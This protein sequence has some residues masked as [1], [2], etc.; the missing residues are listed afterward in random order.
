MN[1]KPNILFIFADDQRAGT[2]GALGNDQIKTPN[3]DILVENGMSFTNGYIQGGS[4]PAVCLPSRAMLHT[5]RSLFS[6]DNEGIEIP[7]CHTLLGEHLRANGYET[8]GTGKWHN[9]SYAYHKSF[10]SGDN[11]FFG[12]MNDHWCVPV[13]RYDPTGKYDK[14]LRKSHARYKAEFMQGGVHSTDF[15]SDSAIDFLKQK[16]EEPFFAYISFLAP[17]DPRTMPDEF[18]NLYN[19]NEINLPENF[20]NY[21][22]IEYDNTQIRDELLAPY[23]RT[24]EDTKN[25]IAEY[26]GMISHLDDRVGKMLS[27]LDESGD[28]ENTIII[29]SGDNGLAIGQHGLFGKQNLYEHS[30]NV[31]LIFSGCGID[32]NVNKDCPVFLF[33]IFPTI[34]DLIGIETPES[35][36]GISFSKVISG[37]EDKTRDVMY[38]CYKDKI[39]AVRK[40]DYKL[41]EHHHN[42]QTTLNL[43]NIKND[44]NEMAN[45]AFDKTHKDLLTQMQ[46]L[47]REQADFYNDNA[48]NEN[49][50]YLNSY[51]K[52]N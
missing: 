31:P 29:Y 9:G 49:N 52:N 14:V 38:H 43:F 4:R 33:D 2:I 44:P 45:L 48:D 12:G 50:P 27:A 37:E 32:K 1:K 46:A 5:G 35:C 26:Y 34:C 40:G 30:I 17:H 41:I 16:H 21:H 47:L 25:Q 7:D 15:I 28:R 22:H 8:F 24:P 13:Y 3:L 18:R 23:P 20:M 10:S 11:I 51:W 36:N 39:R 42:N 19:E 6:L